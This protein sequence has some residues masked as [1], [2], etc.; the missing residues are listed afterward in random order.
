MT[1]TAAGTV[2]A[3][4]ARCLMDPEFL[5]QVT[6]NSRLPFA[7]LSLDDRTRAQLAD[8]DWSRVRHFAG[9]ITKVQHNDLWLILPYTRALLKAYR[10]EIELFARYRASY[11]RKRQVSM[12]AQLKVASFLDFLES[13]IGD[14][15]AK[16][17]GLLDVAR[18]ERMRWRSESDLRAADGL[19]NDE[20]P[21]LDLTSV[22]AGRLST[23]IPST[24]GVLR[25]AVFETDPESTIA[26]LNRGDFNVD[27]IRWQRRWLG[28]WAD[29]SAGRLRLLE[30]DPQTS[31]TLRQ[32]DGRRS[33]AAVLRRAR[34]DGGARAAPADTRRLL[35]A[36]Q[37]Q[38]LLAIRAR[39][40]GPEEPHAPSPR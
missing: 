35:E 22:A 21:E 34:I 36:A 9:F 39:P 37:R 31:F 1:A 13:E 14:D 6:A 4:F 15:P 24:R 26:A 25:L 28:Y 27:D 11:L 3:I 7:A 2:N 17:P 23:V 18:H 32:I 29:P 30:L 10:F 5:A 33:V 16:M 12:T 19:T 8:L 38:G 40:F 20:R